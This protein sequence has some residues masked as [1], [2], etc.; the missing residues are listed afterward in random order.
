[1]KKLLI[2]L[3]AG[4]F[5][6]TSCTENF[7]EIN[8]NP[9][10]VTAPQPG[11][12]F[13]RIV[14]TPVFD[15]QRNVNLFADFYSQYWANT[16][17]SFESGR[18]EYVDGWAA[19][20]WNA[21]Y[22]DGLA[23]TKTLKRLY[24]EDPFY[25]NLTQVL[26]IFECSEWSR[27]MA[28]YGDLPYFGVDFASKVPYNSEKEIYY[29][30][31]ERLTKA[32]NALDSSATDQFVMPSEQDLIYAW[33]LEKW[34][35]FGNSMRLRLA[36]RISNVDPNKAQTEAVAAINAG[37]MQ[38]NND[39]AHVPAWVNGFY[40]YLRNM[41]LLWDNIRAS[42]TFID[43]MY[44][45]TSIED[46][47]AKI[48][49]NYKASSPLFGSARL[50]GVANGYNILPADA[51]DF[52]TMNENTTYIGFSGDGADID[53]YQ[54]I[55]LYPEVLFLQAEAALRGWTSEDPTALMQEGVRASME[56]VGVDSADATT[57]IDELAP[58]S[59][60]KEEQLKQLMTQKYISN[61]PNG[62][63]AWVDFRRTDY[64][65]LTLPIDG[66]SSASTVSSGTYVKRIR[67]PDNAFN[68]EQ[69]MLPADQNTIET[70]RMDKRLWW[71]TADTKTKSNGL[72][73][74]NF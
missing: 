31:F 71:D 1:M 15:Y 69:D 66:V 25:S 67:Y 2:V 62:R 38:S 26:E 36:I 52:A 63:E 49:F 5:I 64:P 37:V 73:N 21:F 7:E 47:R 57:Y 24:G 56:F 35:R 30:L 19:T 27:M 58:L 4:F 51:N 45:Q 10:A 59:G 14:T 53:H 39:V 32:V 16:V 9:N 22:V 74:S 68:S 40:D 43:L 6:T 12:L 33:D 18:Y 65:D 44:S 20:G 54:P 28:Y 8:T 3:T 17:N 13:N 61:F 55:M 50:E 70:N 34:K 72:M 11:Q 60:S 46:P 29:D 42:K 23:N 48:W 41:A